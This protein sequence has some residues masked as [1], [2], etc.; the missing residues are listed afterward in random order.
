M[1][2]SIKDWS[3][4]PASNDIADAGINWQEGMAPSAVNNSARGMMA[5]IKSW[6]DESLGG[7][8]AYAADTGMADA[9]AIAPAPAITAY[10]IGQ[11]FHFFAANENT[12]VSTVNVNALGS[13]AIQKNGAALVSGDIA[14]GGLIQLIYDGTQFQ[15]PSVP[16]GLTLTDLTVDTDTLYVHSVNNR[17]GV[18]TASPNCKLHVRSATNG[19][20]WSPNGATFALF[21]GAVNSYIGIVGGNAGLTALNFGD[22]AAEIRGS[23]EYNN[24]GDV[25]TLVT[26][27]VD[28]VIIGSGGL[29]VVTG[30]FSIGG[31]TALPVNQLLSIS[32][33]ELDHLVDELLL[34]D[35][36]ASAHRKIGLGDFGV[37][38][39][40]QV[41]AKTFTLADANTMQESTSAAAVTWTV[42]PNSSASF[43][44]G[45]VIQVFQSGV[46]QVTIAPGAAVLLRAPNGL[47]I[48]QQYA[49][50]C[51]VKVASDTWV[52]YG[53]VT[54]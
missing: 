40:A 24:N 52:A 32:A 2:N 33:N 14:A 54:P 50:M 38:V 26:A 41:S 15:M 46:G 37:K 48:S 51:I 20:V 21:E 39:I 23:V 13:K 11:A 7:I 17:V 18:G 30:V 42:P 35:N 5:A 1:T 47:K 16:S 10:A 9:Y 31:N 45:T 25:L 43:S 3:T 6:W 34:W 44:I 8:S 36:S 22:T 27:L 12:G 53:D 19:H 4:T 49:V 28:R 29:D